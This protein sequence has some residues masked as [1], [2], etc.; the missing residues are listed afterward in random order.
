MFTNEEHYELAKREWA[1]VLKA[2]QAEDIDRGL[3]TWKKEY[4]PNVYEFRNACKSSESTKAL[5]KPYRALPKP[6]GDPEI[7]N[8]AVHKLSAILKSKSKVMTDTDRIP[9]PVESADLAAARASLTREAEAAA[10][11]RLLNPGGRE[12]E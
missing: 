8:Q 12:A 1:I 4:P 9:D 6:K 10:R 7:A 2:L 11:D 5:H 3:A